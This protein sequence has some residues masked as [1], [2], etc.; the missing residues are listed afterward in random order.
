MQNVTRVAGGPLIA[1]MKSERWDESVA[2]FEADAMADQHAAELQRVYEQTMRDTLAP[3]GL[4][5]ARFGCG[6]TLC[7]G[8][9]LGPLEDGLAR[10]EAWQRQG[11][12]LPLPLFVRYERDNAVQ[13]E[14]RFTFST[15]PSAQSITISP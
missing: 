7:A 15:D 12:G 3:Q 8:T 9:I 14:L 2:R 5:L 11:I 6:L 1:D 13:F 4:G 10:Y